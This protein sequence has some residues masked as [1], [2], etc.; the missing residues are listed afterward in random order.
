[1]RLTNQ[2]AGMC[3]RV[4][5]MNFHLRYEGREGWENIIGTPLDISGM[6]QSSHALYFI[7]KPSWLQAFPV[8]RCDNSLF[9]HKAEA[10]KTC[11]NVGC[12]SMRSSCAMADSHHK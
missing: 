9:L 8:K 12:L 10:T 3:D 2:E 1:M 7:H 4:L 5:G 11:E 6:D